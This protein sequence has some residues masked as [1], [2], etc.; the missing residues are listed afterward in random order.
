MNKKTTQGLSSATHDLAGT[1]VALRT[2]RHQADYA[3][4][5]R[6]YHRLD[7]LAAINSAENA[8]G[9]LEQANIQDHRGFAAHVLFKRRTSLE[10]KMNESRIREFAEEAFKT[11]FG[12]VKLI[13]VNVKVNAR[14]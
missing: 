3:L 5:G 12:N 1:F 8:L 7:A 10:A 6:N 4:E 2:L 13:R 9:L 11:R 14:L